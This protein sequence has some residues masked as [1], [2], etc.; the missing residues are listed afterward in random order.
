MLNKSYYLSFATDKYKEAQKNHIEYAEKMYFDYIFSES[1]ESISEFWEKYKRILDPRISGFREGGGCVW[2]PY[3]ILETLLKMKNNRDWVLYVDSGDKITPEFKKFVEE[4]V[5]S[6]GYMIIQGMH[7]H[8]KYTN[9]ECFET[10]KCDYPEYWNAKQLEAGIL[11][12]RGDFDLY[13]IKEWLGWCLIPE[14]SVSIREDGQ[15]TRHS[16]DQSILTNLVIKHKIP[17]TSILD[18]VPYVSYNFYDS[19]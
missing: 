5:E 2:K 18:V 19:E 1:P 10:M 17:T 7:S 16:G 12:F 14:A 3:I 15:C 9:K 8:R 11:A 4:K 13:F 6:D